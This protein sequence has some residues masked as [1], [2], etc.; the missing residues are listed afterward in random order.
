MHIKQR[1]NCIADKTDYYLREVRGLRDGGTAYRLGSGL[2]VLVLLPILVIELLIVFLTGKD[3]GLI[4]RPK[5][6]SP[7]QLIA[8]EVP[9]SLRDLIPLARK[10]GIG[11][12]AKRE[13]I[14]RAASPAELAELE[15]Q[16]IPRAQE[17]ADW[18]DTFPESG[19]SAT[20]AFFEYLGSACDEVPFYTSKKERII[21]NHHA[22]GRRFLPGTTEW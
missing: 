19:L 1:I 18:L 12:E 14:T 6:A 22:L 4:A 15:E 17:I 20:A 9:E 7:P 10:Y 21:L 8:E 2:L 16:V 13:E 5:P 3:P 11:D